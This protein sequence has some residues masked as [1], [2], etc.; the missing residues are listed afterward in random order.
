[1]AS[2]VIRIIDVNL[3]RASEGL[4]VLEELVRFVL[5]DASLT[6]KLK[7]VRHELV[8]GDLAFNR[9]LLNARRADTDV[10]ADITLPGQGG[11][12]LAE[13]AVSNSRRVQ[14]ALRVLEE[15]AK[16]DDR[17][18]GLSTD[19]L[20][21]ARFDLY[22]IEQ[23]LTLK[24]L[25][26]EKV[27]SVCGLYPIIDTQGL[28][29]EDHIGIA[30]AVIKGGA[31]VI[32]FRDKVQ[33]KRDVFPIAVELRKLCADSG[34]TF[35]MNDYLDVAL[36]TDA[37]GLHVGQED[38][39]AKEARRLLPQDKILGVSASS[40]ELAVQAEKDGADYIGHGAIFPT[41]SKD[42]ARAVGLSR[43]PEIK[44]AVSIPVVAIGGINQ[45]NVAEIVRAGADGIAVISAILGAESP[46]AA[47]RDMIKRIKKAK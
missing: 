22:T 40:L 23:E 37:D 25:R 6:E 13:L 1:M 11:K 44:K 31:K 36:A 18:L 12:A 30:K 14:E 19:S 10:G 3:N 29:G 2:E 34:V 43:L 21:R 45:N 16:L 27:Q 26:K 33:N 8:I 46:E 32:Q 4:R 15:I 17:G 41:G 39:S 28:K 5:N 47:T 9:R 20:R 42:G 24:L 38:L 7:S 35:I